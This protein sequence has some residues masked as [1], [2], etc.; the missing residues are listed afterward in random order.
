MTKQVTSL[1]G[2]YSIINTLGERQKQV[3]L[4]LKSLGIANNMMISGYLNIPLQ[5]VCGRMNELRHKGIVIYHHT[6]ACPI[7]KSTTRFFTIKS[8]IKES[9]G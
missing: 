9:M 7:M 3:L 4:A 6:G 2:Y 5:S 8:Y 1:I